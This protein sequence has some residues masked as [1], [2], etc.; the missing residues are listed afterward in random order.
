VHGALFLLERGMLRLNPAPYAI[1][2]FDVWAS[3]PVIGSGRSRHVQLGL[4]F[5][6]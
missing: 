3:N 5:Q 2:T 4:K 1:G 6:F